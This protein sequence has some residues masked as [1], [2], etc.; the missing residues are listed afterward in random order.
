MHVWETHL[1][2][3]RWTKFAVFSDANNNENMKRRSG[4]HGHV[5]LKPINIWNLRFY[6]TIR[7][8]WG[9]SVKHN[10]R[11]PFISHSS[12]LY[13]VSYKTQQQHTHTETARHL[14]SCWSGRSAV[15]VYRQK[16][17]GLNRCLVQGCVRGNAQEKC[18]ECFLFLCR[19]T[20]HNF[21][22]ADT[23]HEG[24]E[25]MTKPEWMRLSESVFVCDWMFSKVVS[26]YTQLAQQQCVSHARS[27]QLSAPVTCVWRSYAVCTCICTFKS[28]MSESILLI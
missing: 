2:R 7:M 1:P 22:E 24:T 5:S 20:V 13:L 18:I 15:D 23:N 21:S 6:Y 14:H 10:M 16:Y 4:S 11:N 9:S 25:P 28:Q 17:S 19:C 27:S 26:I 12:N 3:T 8:C